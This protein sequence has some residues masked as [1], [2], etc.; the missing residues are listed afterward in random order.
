MTQS[1][2]PA[3]RETIFKRLDS[4]AGAQAQSVIAEFIQL[5]QVGNISDSLLCLE[6]FDATLGGFGL[7]TIADRLT[8]QGIPG[9]TIDERDIYRPIQ[10]VR[11]QLEHPSAA[12]LSRTIVERSCGHVEAVLK[13]TARSGFLERFW[14]GE[15][16]MGKL[17]RDKFKG[18]LPTDLYD[19]LLWLN[20]ELYIFA[21]HEFG[22][23]P[24]K[25]AEE[26]YFGLDE[27]VAVY[28]IAR[29][30]VVHVMAVSSGK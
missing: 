7:H 23:R 11:M 25:E 24:E 4:L 14:S 22:A 1:R 2:Q 9:V 18:K 10:Y 8:L 21:K 19:N 5:H 17:L 26:S 16:P 29:S 6:K 20:D 27:T 15:L 30:L 13:K 3:T 28:F 12:F